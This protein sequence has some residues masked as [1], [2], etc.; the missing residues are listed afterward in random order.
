[1]ALSNRQELLD[2]MVDWL[3][4]VG[5]SSLAARCPDFIVLHEARAN[6]VLRDRQMV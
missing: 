4:R 3:N 2:A 1:M 5:S 6:R